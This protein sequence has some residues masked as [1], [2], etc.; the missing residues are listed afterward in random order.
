MLLASDS[1]TNSIADVLDEMIDF[2]ED[3]DSETE[4][5]LFAGSSQ[6]VK[7]QEPGTM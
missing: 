7:K 2:G 4:S 1:P 5:A 6:G 3:D